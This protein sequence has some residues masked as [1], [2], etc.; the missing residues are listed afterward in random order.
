MGQFFITKLSPIQNIII[1]KTRPRLQN[2]NAELFGFIK[3]SV[4]RTEESTNTIFNDEIIILYFTPTK[5]TEK[6]SF[7]NNLSPRLILPDDMIIVKKESLVKREANISINA[8]GSSGGIIS[9]VT[10]DAN[11]KLWGLIL[12]ALAIVIMWF[13]WKAI[14]IDGFWKGIIPRFWHTARYQYQDYIFFIITLIIIGLIAT[15]MTRTTEQNATMFGSV[16]TAFFII[17]AI[18]EKTTSF[19]NFVGG[20]TKNVAENNTD[21]VEKEESMRNVKYFDSITSNFSTYVTSWMDLWDFKNRFSAKTNAKDLNDYIARFKLRAEMGYIVTS[22]IDEAIKIE[23]EDILS[24][25]RDSKLFKSI[26]GEYYIQH[27]GSNNT[28]SSNI[29]TA[30][31]EIKKYI[32]T[33]LTK[34]SSNTK[35]ENLKQIEKK[36]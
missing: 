4:N 23:L 5:L 35:Q 22:N 14:T 11:V 9:T 32:D 1:N 27:G 26:I 6:R 16:F 15:V 30:V 12:F 3:A 24:R 2:N 25:F 10:E 29:D 33:D 13:L 18:V 28:E 34:I 31:A 8:G 21:F 36:Y 19:F 17:M 20:S 7:M